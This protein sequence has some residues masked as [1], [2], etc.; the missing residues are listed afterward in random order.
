MLSIVS[1]NK[2]TKSKTYDVV[3]LLQEL[4]NEFTHLKFVTENR[5]KKLNGG[6]LVSEYVFKLKASYGRVH[7]PELMTTIV[8]GENEE[9]DHH[10]LIEIKKNVKKYLP[11]HYII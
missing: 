3:D 11:K 7:V 2:P 5:V 9:I 1:I 10:T 4:N 8:I 6:N